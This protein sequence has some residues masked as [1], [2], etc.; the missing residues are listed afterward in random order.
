M[1]GKRNITEADLKEFLYRPF[2]FVKAS[3]FVKTTSDKSADKTADK[4][5]LCSDMRS[6]KRR[7]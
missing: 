7:A 2:T 3:D 1:N 4:P 5:G 6:G